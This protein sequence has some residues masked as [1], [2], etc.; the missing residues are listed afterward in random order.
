M[1]NEREPHMT[2]QPAL[3]TSL[4]T[5]LLYYAIIAM[6]AI[7]IVLPAARALPYSKVAVSLML[8]ALL[9]TSVRRGL[10]SGEMK[11]S[12]RQIHSQAKQGRRFAPQAIETAALVAA[13]IAFWMTI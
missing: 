10:K 13:S 11:L 7:F 12:L 3:Q 9:V 4:A 5:Y 6:S 2:N 8:F 1:L